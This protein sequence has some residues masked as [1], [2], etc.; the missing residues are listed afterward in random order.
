MFECTWQEFKR[1]NKVILNEFWISSKLDP[2]RPLSRLVPRCAIR[3]GFN[4]LYQLQCEAT[5]NKAIYYFD[6]NSLYSYIARDMNFPI[7]EYQVILENDL[8][9][10]LKIENNKFFYKDE[11][12]SCDI[13]HV[14]VLAPRDMYAPFLSYRFGEQSFNSLCF[15]CVQTKNT[16]TCRHKCP[17]K[18][19][20]TS[21]YTVIELE[22]ALE[23]GY[24]IL[25]VYELYHY[26]RKAPV[27]SNFIKVIS[28]LKLKS[29]DLFQNVAFCDRQQV[30]DSLNV[31]MKFDDPSLTLT[32]Q[33]VEP[34][35]S[36]KQYLKNL[37]N[38]LFGRF[39]LHTNYS[40][41]E[42]VKSQAQLDSIL[43]KRE[44]ELLDFFPVSDTTMQVE[45]IKNGAAMISREGNLFYTALINAKARIFMYNYIQTLTKENCSVI[46]VDTDSLLFTGPADYKLPFDTTSAFGDFKPVL[47]STAVI[48]KFYSLGCKNYCILYNDMGKLSYVTKIKGLSV[49]SHNLTDK[50]SPETYENFIKAHFEDKVMNEYVPQ[51][52]CKLE[53]QT[54][55]FKQIMLTQ[56]FSNELHLKRFILKKTRSFVTYPFGYNFVNVTNI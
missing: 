38:G 44:N 36:Q 45:Y 23:L 27:L 28:S 12:C 11:D 19:R 1:K 30:C 26:S 7:G 31:K 4:E 24:V 53:K 50:I 15:K 10:H 37:L 47:G 18:R 5:E 43:A 13:A 42:F 16:N 33:N 55:T 46:Y 39:A 41:R 51:S 17:Y 21:T 40:L 56:K 22:K 32:P 2:K 48:K 20:F 9:Q 25:Y 49:N 52:R 54:R 29:T 8:K 6:C 14:S 35:E 34:N 3:S